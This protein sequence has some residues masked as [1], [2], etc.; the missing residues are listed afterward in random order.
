MKIRWL[1]DVLGRRAGT[2]EVVEPNNA[3]RAWIEAGYAE[4]I[5]RGRPRRSPRTTEAKGYVIKDQ[6]VALNPS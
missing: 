6:T 3:V 4:E 2:E 1:K 5:K